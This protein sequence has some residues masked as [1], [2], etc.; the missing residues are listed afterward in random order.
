[1]NKDHLHPQLLNLFKISEIEIK[2]KE[3]EKDNIIP[4][5]RKE[6]EGNIILKVGDDTEVGL[7]EEEGSLVG[8]PNRSRFKK[9]YKCSLTT[10]WICKKM[11]QKN[12]AK[13]NL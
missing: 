1:M 3:E 8:N 12:K 13:V 4:I 2:K 11:S 5:D 6:E 10:Q 9:K 7:E